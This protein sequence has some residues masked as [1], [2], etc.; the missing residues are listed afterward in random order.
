MEHRSLV[1]AGRFEL[2]VALI[3]SQVPEATRLRFQKWE[4][5]GISKSRLRVCK[6]RT[7]P[8]S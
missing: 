4:P 8:L 6:T 3:K 5:P 2:T 7:L 1:E